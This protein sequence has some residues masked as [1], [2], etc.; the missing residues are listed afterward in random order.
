MNELEREIRQCIAEILP[1]SEKHVN[2]RTL[3]EEISVSINVVGIPASSPDSPSTRE[4]V[5][6][7]RH[8]I[9]RRI[10]RK[11]LIAITASD[12]EL[13]IEQFLLNALETRLPG[14]FSDVVVSSVLDK[15][16]NVWVNPTKPETRLDAQVAQIASSVCTEFLGLI[17]RSLGELCVLGADAV[18]P[19]PP[20]LLKAVKVLQPVGLQAIAQA[21]RQAGFESASERWLRNQLD[22][23]RRHKFLQ[24]VRTE[25]DAADGEY[26]LTAAGL[27]SIPS[28]LGK[29]SSDIARAL[30]L[31]RKRW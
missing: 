9:Q 11:V 15:T 2:V 1:K 23:L 16:L 3:G 20:M 8:S 30:A 10:N 14:L 17:G 21:V 5:S 7:L 19:S 24:F 12:E 6:Q 29:E 28:K 18:L 27:A 22:S 13:H 26:V 31:A 25:G 4:L